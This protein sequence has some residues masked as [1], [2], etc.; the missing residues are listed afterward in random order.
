MALRDWR[1]RRLVGLSFLWL[2]IFAAGVAT[3]TDLQI[4]KLERE[5][6]G[7]PAYFVANVPA[8]PYLILGPPL[9]LFAAWAWARRSRPAS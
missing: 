1:L 6:P 2:L 3:Y 9:L 4:R 8:V 7:R 5:Y